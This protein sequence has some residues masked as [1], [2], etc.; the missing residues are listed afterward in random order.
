LHA[1]VP[2]TSP[3]DSAI[4]GLIVE[5]HAKGGDEAGAAQLVVSFKLMGIV[6][7]TGFGR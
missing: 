4:A 1:C 2:P 6:P 5:A 3:P 7:D